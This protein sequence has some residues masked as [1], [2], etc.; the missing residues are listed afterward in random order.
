MISKS[1]AYTPAVGIFEK[2]PKTYSI[3]KVGVDEV[4]RGVIV[5]QI[6]ALQKNVEA[7]FDLVADPYLFDGSPDGSI[8]LHPDTP[9]KMF[10]KVCDTL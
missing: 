8:P 2:P 9:S 3:R 1:L 7:G 4:M 5:S 6:K 10:R